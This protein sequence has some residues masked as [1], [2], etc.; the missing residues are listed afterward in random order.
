MR[1]VEWIRASQAILFEASI[2][3]ALVGTAAAIA[4][5][6]PFRAAYLVLILASLVGIQ[7]GANLL[8]GYYEGE[9]RPGPPSL[10][11]SWVGFDSGAAVGLGEAPRNVLRA[12]R[13]AF[14]IGVLAG[15][16][17]VVVTS[18]VVLLAF[19]IAGATLAWSYSAPPLKLSYRGIGELSTFFA[20]GPIMTLGATIAFGGR[21][22][23]QSLVASV[24]L[25]FLASA[26]SFV[27][28]FP[29]QKEDRAKGKRTPVTILGLT[30]ARSLFFGLFVVALATLGLWTLSGAYRAAYPMLA[31]VVFTSI[32][33]F[34]FPNEG[35]PPRAYERAIALTI[36]AHIVVGIALIAQFLL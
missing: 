23:E 19:G 16:V 21:G 24:V 7:A 15:L 22:I 12:G 14:A 5:G 8:K 18:N 27:R 10:R 34:V 1:L 35:A 6:A 3:P 26:I 20:F 29:N 36:T 30:T 31:L 17:L 9:G 11:G 4:A 13:I 33:F 28:Y 25:G 32:L 2:I